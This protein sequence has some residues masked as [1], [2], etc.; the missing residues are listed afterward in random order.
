MSLKRIFVFLFVFITLL[1]L[2]SYTDSFSKYNEKDEW[3]AFFRAI[4]E[5][6]DKEEVDR[7]YSLY[8][9]SD[10]SDVEISRAEYNYIRYLVDNKEAD[11]A[12]LHLKK[13]EEAIERMEGKNDYLSSYSHLDY[14]SSSYY[15]TKN[16]SKGIEN[17]N[18]TKELYKKYND[19][20][21]IIITNA[22]RLIYTPQIA[23]GSNK[24]AISILLPL[25]EEKEIISEEDLYSIYGALST[26]YYNR[27]DYDNA[28]AYLK[29]ALEIYNG[30]PTILELKEK[31]DKK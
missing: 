28:K 5:N 22:W 20:I 7:L 24:N 6:K 1:P 8:I 23:G 13:Q 26:A 12:K 14:I 16:I 30:E 19:E 10:L 2:F 4:K 25:L 15:I 17:S 29:L 18:Q 9:S 3:K 21:T 11:E 27:K 31:L